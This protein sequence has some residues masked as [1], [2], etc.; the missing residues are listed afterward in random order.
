MVSE[1]EVCGTKTVSSPARTPALSNQAAIWAVISYRPL[2]R[3]AT[4]RRW[5]VICMGVFK[6]E[7]VYSTERRRDAEISAE[8]TLGDGGQLPYPASRPRAGQFQHHR[9]A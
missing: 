1:A 3:V 8:N 7:A 9:P 5:E 2:P 4:W 6:L